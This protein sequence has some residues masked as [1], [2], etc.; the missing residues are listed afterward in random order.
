MPSHL[1]HAASQNSLKISR[2]IHL[3]AK[4]TRRRIPDEN[5]AV[6]QALGPPYVDN[7]TRCSIFSAGGA[8]NPEVIRNKAIVA[9]RRIST[10]PTR[11][12]KCKE[13]SASNVELVQPVTFYG[14]FVDADVSP[15]SFSC[16]PPLARL[17]AFPA[18]PELPAA[19]MEDD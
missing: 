4:R 15:K 3:D 1:E 9:Q 6:R 13:K 12:W 7:F 17:A 14:L 8:H 11:R 19:L 5:T 16:C 18:L 10:T 2:R